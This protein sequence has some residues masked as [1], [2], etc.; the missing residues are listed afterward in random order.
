MTKMFR[1]LKELTA[2]QAPKKVLIRE[3]AR[4]PITKNINSIFVIRVEEEK[5]IANNEAIGE[6]IVKPSKS[7]E[8]KPLKEVDETNKVDDKLAKSVKENIT[9]NEEEEPTS[10]S[11]S[12]AVGK[13]KRKTYNL[14][15]MGLV[16]EAILKKKITRKE[17]IGGNFEIPCNIGG[18]KH[19]NALVDQGS[20]VNA[21]PL[22]TYRK[23]TDERP[24][25]TDIRL[26]LARH[27]YIYP[28][29]IALDVLV[30]VAGYVYPVDFVI[31]DIK[32]DEKRP[33]ILGIPFLTTAKAKG[34]KNDIEH[35][36]PTMTVNRLVLEWEERIKLHQ[37]KEMD[38][39]KWRS[40][41]FKN[42]HPALV[43]VKSEMKDEGEV[44]NSGVTCEEEAK[45]SNYGAKTKTFE[46][47][48][49]LLLYTVSNK[50]DTTYPL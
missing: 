20:D 15:P 13:M 49:Y 5:N 27:S 48:H 18:L 4:H 14:L 32:E 3:D 22:S 1:L 47:N 43:K 30:D 7:E 39:E 11:S 23:L 31:L 2:S 42:K 40:K 9:N 46:E 36:A 33:I 26:S 50:E 12:H 21:M 44:T 28:L 25:E 34:I 24:A 38:F 17:D 35:I 19:M 8:E 29:G 41:D 45:R 37:E 16:Y 10:V 6:S